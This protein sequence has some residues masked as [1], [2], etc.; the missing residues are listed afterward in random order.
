M[1]S[2]GAAV[3]EVRAAG[4]VLWRSA[5]DGPEIALVH[6]PRYDDWAFPKGKA[7]P[8]EHMLLTA[9]REVAEETGVRVVLGRRL[10]TVRYLAHGKPKRVDY[11]AARPADGTGAGGFTPNDEIDDLAWLPVA[12]ARDKLS[13]AHDGALLEEFGS[14]PAGTVPIILV[15]HAWARRKD[16]WQAGHRD[17]LP[18]PLTR[19][20][21]LQAQELAGILECFGP[22]RVVSSA[23]ERCVASVAPFAE[24][25]GTKVEMEPA[26]TVGQAGWPAAAQRQILGLVAAGQPLVV[27][28]HRENL[29]SLLAWACQGLGAQVPAGPSLPK[30]G[31]WVLHT[32]GGR[33][34]TAERHV[35]SGT[36]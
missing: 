22:A 4:A 18:R 24:L 7:L 23:A 10:S 6:R 16:T 31:F 17:D 35:L 12:A 34:A 21:Q 19:H 25:A 2:G 1:T 33:L 11:W 15:R 26:F 32:A 29:P 5:A 30:G 3:G 8:G 28:A 20:G 13:Y 14:G 9:V 36:S 27:C